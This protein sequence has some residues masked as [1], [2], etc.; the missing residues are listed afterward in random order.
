MTPVEVLGSMIVIVLMFS[1]LLAVRR[2]QD[3]KIRQRMVVNS[4]GVHKMPTMNQRIDAARASRLE[5]AKLRLRLKP[6]HRACGFV[7]GAW[8]PRSSRLVDELPALLTALVPRFGTVDRLRYHQPNWSLVSQTVKHR[9]A[10]VLLEVG[11]ELQNT[12]TLF[13]K[14]FGQLTL[15]VVPVHTDAYAAHTAMAT[16]AKAGDASTPERLLSLGRRS[17]A[18]SRHGLAAVQSWESEGGALASPA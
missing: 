2:M 14:R 5:K 6:S 7:Q 17:A 12:V 15:L 18:D 13:G 8:W 9:R 11:P 10:D 4:K 3:V 16:A 1:A